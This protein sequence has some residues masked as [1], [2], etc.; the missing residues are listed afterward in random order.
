[1]SRT[2]PALAMEENIL[3]RFGADFRLAGVAGEQRF[4]KLTY[5]CLTSRLL[6]WGRP[7]SRPVS[8]IGKG[9]TSTGKS[10]TLGTVLRFFPASAY[11]NLGSMSKRYLMYM[12]ESL[13][14]RFLV[15]PEWASIAND[16]DI[17]PA[18]R[19]LLSEGRL[20]HGTVSADGRQEARRIEKEGPTGLLMTTTAA[21]VDSELETRCLT[22]FTDDTPEQTRRVYEVLAELENN[23]TDPVRW[24]LWRELQEWLAGHGERR[25]QIPYV[26]ALAHLFPN[27]ATRLR[28]DFVSM[29]SLIRSHAILH[30]ATREKDDRGRIVATIADYEHVSELVGPLI[31]QGADAAVSAAI[32]DTV[33]TVR[34]LLQDKGSEFVTVK[35]IT[36]ALFVGRSAAY[37]RIKRALYHGYLVDLASTNERGKKIA[38]GAALP[39]ERLYLPT[40][41]DIVRLVSYT[42]TGPAD[43]AATANVD[44]SSGRPGRP[45]VFGDDGYL[46][47][48]DRAVKNG[49][50]LEH[51]RRQRRLLHFTARRAPTA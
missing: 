4:A 16:P 14:H 33:D 41:D 35:A 25:V 19:T 28:R 31:A 49:H 44:G 9:T 7:T 5:L 6:E 12:E 47:L 46:E 36:E 2:P 3:D 34:W 32:R 30:Q 27:D 37:D 51:E 22:D 15:I 39:D 45:I 29:L 11:L 20:I 13:S 50:L 8:M 26:V 42:R 48:L 40:G 38:I 43:P 18:L 17:V 10:H 24:E 21:A 1:V 23:D